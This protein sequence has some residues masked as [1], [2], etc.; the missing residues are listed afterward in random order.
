DP[1]AAAGKIS[2][3][4]KNHRVA[5]FPFVPAQTGTQGQTLTKKLPP[6]AGANGERACPRTPWHSCIL[7]D[8]QT[9]E[10][11][12]PQLWSGLG[13]ARLF[14][15]SPKGGGVARRGGRGRRTRPCHAPHR[16]SPFSRPTAPGPKPAR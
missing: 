2:G 6:C 16:F 12:R 1:P 13:V 11:Q 4:R 8:C 15:H 5:P 9:A 3:D 7:F 14:F 10:L